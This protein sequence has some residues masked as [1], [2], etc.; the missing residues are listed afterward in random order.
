M[1]ELRLFDGV[2]DR[3]DRRLVKE[4]FAI[5]EDF[6]D[7][8]G[9]GDVAFDKFE[10]AFDRGKVLWVARAEIIEHDNRCAAFA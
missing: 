1:G 9:V 8:C 7:E 10:M 4:P 3:G 5:G 2:G 6:V